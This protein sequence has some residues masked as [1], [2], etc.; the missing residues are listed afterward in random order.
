MPDMA[1]DITVEDIEYLRH[2][3]RPLLMRLMRPV[4]A[5][6]L[7]VVLDLHGG[8]WTEG[9]RRSCAMRDEI[10]A[11][12]GIASAALDFRQGTDGYLASMADLNYAVRWL[13]A[14]APSLALDANR[15][16]FTG[17]SSGGHLAMLAAM[18]PTDPRYTAIPLAGIDG[19]YDARVRAVGVVAPVINPLSRYRRAVRAKQS[20]NSP[21]WAGRIPALHDAYWRTEEAMAEG[22]PTLILERGEAVEM[23]PVLYIQG[24]PDA[25]HIYR[26]PEGGDDANEP[27]RFVRLYRARGG[28]IDFRYVDLESDVKQ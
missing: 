17:A 6:P 4:G 7:P 10:L 2:G 5:E 12:A 19:H 11:R 15:M 8:A 3:D 27:E 23:P 20:P 22:S 1:Q 28:T 18:R 24:R 13:K 26:D 25:A 16:G 14:Q 21:A 9:D